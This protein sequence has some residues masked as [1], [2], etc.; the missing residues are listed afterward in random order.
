MENWQKY[1]INEKDLEDLKKKKIENQ[2]VLIS[3]NPSTFIILHLS[4]FLPSFSKF[5]S[6]KSTRIIIRFY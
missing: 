3:L 6:R 2:S 5:L 4:S 1:V